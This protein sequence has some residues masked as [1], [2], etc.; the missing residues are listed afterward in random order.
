MFEDYEGYGALMP[1]LR[2]LLFNAKSVIFSCRKPQQVTLW[3]EDNDVHLP[4]NPDAY[5]DF[6]NANSS[7]CGERDLLIYFQI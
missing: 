3:W 2:W 6:D 5:L 7:Q 4:L 1:L